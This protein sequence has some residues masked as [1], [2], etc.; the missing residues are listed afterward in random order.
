[1]SSQTAVNSTF[2]PTLH[3]Q[4]VPKHGFPQV[5]PQNLTMTTKKQRSRNATAASS[6][7]TRF[8]GNKEAQSF[9][10]SIQRCKSCW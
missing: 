8:S 9:S 2:H 1:M 6:A 5:L 10:M 3:H 7:A 4:G